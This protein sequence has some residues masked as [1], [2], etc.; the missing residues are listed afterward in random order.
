MRI[1]ASATIAQINWKT[2]RLS[3]MRLKWMIN[4]PRQLLKMFQDSYWSGGVS[5]GS[6]LHVPLWCTASV[7]MSF[8]FTLKTIFG[9]SNSSLFTTDQEPPLTSFTFSR[10][11]LNT[12]TTCHS[13]SSS[14]I[15]TLTTRTFGQLH[16]RHATHTLTTT[17]MTLEWHWV[18]DMYSSHCRTLGTASPWPK[19]GST[20]SVSYTHLT[21]P[22]IY[23]V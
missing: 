12:V 13:L 4:V 9:R 17:S 22:T 10:V 2:E 15:L 1:T 18:Q 6:S 8:T 23:S 19:L 20:M 21:L 16:H 3:S 14:S 11:L 5:A 7:T